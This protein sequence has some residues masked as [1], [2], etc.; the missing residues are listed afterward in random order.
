MNQV[1]HHHPVASSPK[2]QTFLCADRGKN[3]L[4]MLDLCCGLKGASQA[5][6]AAGW[7][8]ITVDIDERF[9]PDIV[10]DLVTWRYDGPR[11]D[12]IWASPP[13]TEFSRE[14]MPWCRTGKHPDLSIVLAALRIIR[15]TKPKYWIIENVRGAIRWFRPFLGEPRASFGPFFLWGF[16]PF[17]GTQPIHYRPKE[18]Y[19]SSDPAGRVR[20]PEQISRAVMTSISR[21][22][23]LF[24]YS[25]ISA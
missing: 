15:E 6:H 12:L 10:A 22:P 18:S 17:S 24:N 2:A 7:S 14:S 1:Q 16:F 3:D 13:C 25:M 8:V 9:H 11:P 20:I 19:S 4:L 23:M 5:M 21:H